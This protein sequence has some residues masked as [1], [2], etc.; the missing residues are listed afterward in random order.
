MIHLH[1]NYEHLKDELLDFI[2]DF[3]NQGVYVTKG[4]RNIIKKVEIQGVVYNVKSFSKPN[5]FNSFVYKYVRPSKAKRSFEFAE[6]LLKAEILTPFPVSYIEFTSVLGLQQSYYVSEHVDYDFDFRNL[7]HEPLFPNREGI[8]KQFTDFTFKLHENNINFLDHSPGNTLIINKGNGKY[9]FYLIDLNRLKFESL[10]L[11]ESMENLKRLWLS[12]QMIQIIAQRYAEL[13][14]HS[15]D[16]V[17]HLLLKSSRKFK[18]KI[19][20]KK[21]WKRKLKPKKK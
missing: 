19:N 14:G 5:F 17:F 13:S 9:Q 1:T 6:K 16:Q 15:Y 11:P 21:Y 8:L 12:K 10:S 3:D 20:K 18:V 2:S 4:T 7:I